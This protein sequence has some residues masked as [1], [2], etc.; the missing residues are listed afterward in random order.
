[1]HNHQHSAR[2]ALQGLSTVPADIV[3]EAEFVEW[4]CD[5]LN[6]AGPTFLNVRETRLDYAWNIPSCL[7]DA[8]S[9]NT[10][11]LSGPFI[12]R[13][14]S[15]LPPAWN[16]LYLYSVIFAPTF[17]DSP[18]DGFNSDGTV[19]WNEVILVVLFERSISLIPTSW[20]LFRALCHP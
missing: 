12:I 13:D 5:V 8:S 9:V 11:T 20:A 18:T 14:F 16:G 1:M 4:F 15:A 7:A 6:G 19:N 3:A 10:L 17:S 2:E